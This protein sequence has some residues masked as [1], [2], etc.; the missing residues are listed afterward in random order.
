M[1]HV[2]PSGPMDKASDYESGDSRFESW[3]GR[4]FLE[5]EKTKILGQIIKVDILKRKIRPIKMIINQ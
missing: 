2:W 4:L 5:G 3:W 1:Y